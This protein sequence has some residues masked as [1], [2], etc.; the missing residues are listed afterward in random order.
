MQRFFP[1]GPNRKEFVRSKMRREI[2]ICVDHGDAYGNLGDEAML[3][4]ALSRLASHLGPCRFVVLCEPD[5]PMALH[6]PPLEKIPPPRLEF[7][8]W[9]RI[10]GRGFSFLSR[11][12]LLEKVQ[13]SCVGGVLYSLPWRW[14]SLKVFLWRSGVLKS[15]GR[16]LEP[17]LESVEKCD[18]FYAVGAA[19]LN[20]FNLSGAVYKLWLYRM[21]SSSARATV[22]SAQGIG[23]LRT[24]WAADLLAA[25]LPGLDLLSFRD[26][27]LGRS[28]VEAYQPSHVQYEVVADE[29]FTLPPA[30]ESVASGYIKNAGLPD[31]ASFLAVHFRATDYTRETSSLVPRICRLLDSIIDT[32]GHYLVFFPMSYHRHSRMDQELGH[33]I[34]AKMKNTGKMLVGPVSRDVRIVKGAVAKARYSLGL[35]YHLHLFALSTGHPAI[36]LYTG[37]Y[38]KCKAEG[39]IGFYGAPNVAI[40][41]DES[42]DRHIIQQV[43]RLE[44]EYDDAC[45]SIAAVNEELVQRNDWT[46]RQLALILEERRGADSAVH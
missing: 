36:V 42:E 8:W 9:E 34:R 15:P 1:D 11:I 27:S 2:T 43:T 26:C 31:G 17:F 45:K 44:Q 33:R 4:N 32:Y 39:L 28:I 18:A 35:S 37:E 12:P 38:Y 46:L 7:A 30:P 5:K 20:D 3:L 29:A 6:L 16:Y 10:I 21:A 40:D 22:L 13:R 19:Q 25:T 41:L 24:R 14:G 23:P